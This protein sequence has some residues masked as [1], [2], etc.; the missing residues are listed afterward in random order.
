[1]PKE[2]G[3]NQ[4]ETICSLCETMRDINDHIAS[5][6]CPTPKIPYASPMTSSTTS[7]T[8]GAR[9]RIMV[10]IVAGC[11]SVRTVRDCHNSKPL[12]SR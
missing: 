9:D 3:F 1:M 7:E 12:H 11:R 4:S 5:P 2:C 8:S 6:R 10:A